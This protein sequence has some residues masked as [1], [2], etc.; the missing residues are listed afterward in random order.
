[1]NE[2]WLN[3]PQNAFEH[4]KYKNVEENDIINRRK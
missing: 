3:L 1:M 4:I 2:V